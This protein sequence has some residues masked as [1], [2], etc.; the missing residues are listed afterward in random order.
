MLASL[1]SVSQGHFRLY[2]ENDAF[3]ISKG[4]GDKYFTNGIRLEYIN[5]KMKMSFLQ[6]I[7]PDA[8]GA[9]T[10]TYSV[11]FGQNL[12]TQSDIKVEEL[13]PGDRPYAGYLYLNHRKYS[14]NA[15]SRI[16]YTSEISVG[17]IGPAAFGKQVQTEFH[18][19]INSPKPLG[20]HHQIKNNPA[21]NYNIEIEH[22]LYDSKDDYMDLIWYMNAEV[23]TV[24]DNF[25]IGSMIRFSPFRVLGSYFE[26]AFSKYTTNR[27][28]REGLEG[29]DSLQTTKENKLPRAAARKKPAIIFFAKP[30]ARFVA[31]NALLQGGIFNGHKNERTISPDALERVYLNFDFGAIVAIGQRFDVVF[32]QSFRTA[33]FQGAPVHYWAFLNIIYNGRNRK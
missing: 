30:S 4:R 10:T 11:T 29:S 17:I 25:G 24:Y 22:Q 1:C 31:F 7:L 5:P 32:G 28:V 6:R 19:I 27:R 16:R 21:I 23:G 26:S 15:I 2:I 3:A 8:P 13:I 20:W 9:T 18:E 33:E 14:N 12:Y